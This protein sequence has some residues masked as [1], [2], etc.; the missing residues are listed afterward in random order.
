MRVRFKGFDASNTNV[1]LVI[2]KN[3]NV[4]LGQ[5]TGFTA[6]AM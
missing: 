6:F 4:M 5:R 1:M 2:S 3:V